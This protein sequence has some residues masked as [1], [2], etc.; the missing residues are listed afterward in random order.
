MNLSTAETIRTQIRSIPIGAQFRVI[1]SPKV[2][3]RIPEMVLHLPTVGFVVNCVY[4]KPKG[5][6]DESDMIC[7]FFTPQ[8]LCEYWWPK[9][10]V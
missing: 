8:T 5:E 7:D 6:H 1:N 4:E 10:N 3:V 9:I 2:F